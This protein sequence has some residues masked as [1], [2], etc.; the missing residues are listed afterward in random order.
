MSHLD[1]H[2]FICRED[3]Y[4]CLVHDGKTGATASIDAPDASAIE[5]ELKK[6]GWQLTHIFTTHHHGDHVEGN[7]ALKEQFACKIVGPALEADR[8]P[9]IDTQVKGGETFAFAGRD[10][11]VID[12]PGHT[13][14][15]IAYHI[16][17][18]YSVFVGDT[19]F[20]LGCGRVMEG[21]M[22]QMQASLAA[23]G[24]L[25]PNTYVYS[26]HEYTVANAK[27]CI[28]MEPGN[29]A[30]Q[31]RAALVELER[32]QGKFTVPSILGDELKTNVFLRWD[33]AEIRERLALKDAG[34]A[35]VFRALRLKKNNFK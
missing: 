4:G 20:P 21:T 7:L 25:S 23:L 11:H 8:I 35:E 14:G 29:R 31:Q 18:D 15:H 13:L 24:K 33:S 5:R 10:V 32:A 6:R 12:T 28:A 26:G 34:G 16:P 22:E 27:F 3:N 2:L 19:L 17:E 1:M 9:G 30:L